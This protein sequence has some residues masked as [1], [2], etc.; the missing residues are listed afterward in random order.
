LTRFADT[1]GEPG[2]R[3]RIPRRARFLGAY[4]RAF[5]TIMAETTTAWGKKIWLEKTPDHVHCIE[6]IQD[7]LG[8]VDFI[9][10]IRNGGEVIASLYEV[11]HRYPLRWK[12]AW[13]LERCT[14]KWIAAVATSLDYAGK[15]HHLLVSYDDLVTSCSE[16]LTRICSFLR[17]EFSEEMLVGHAEAAEAV[18]GDEP[19]KDMV[20]TEVLRPPPKFERL[21]SRQEQCYVRERIDSLQ[22]R[23]DVTLELVG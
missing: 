2:L 7:H 23:V 5:E 8:T 21:F 15:P 19:W 6:T 18:I 10:L 22:A 17:I 20:M 13:S 3:K 4:A 1:I 12:G 14:D 11:T 16:A 9:H